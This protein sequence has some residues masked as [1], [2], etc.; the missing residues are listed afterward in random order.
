MSKTLNMMQT[1]SKMSEIIDLQSEVNEILFNLLLQYES[2]EAFASPK[3]TKK[4]DKI[5]SLK[6]EVGCAP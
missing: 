1:F 6:I 2:A 3:L 5:D 4:M